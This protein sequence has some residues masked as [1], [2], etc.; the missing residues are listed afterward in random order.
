MTSIYSGLCSVKQTGRG[1]LVGDAKVSTAVVFFFLIVFLVLVGLRLSNITDVKVVPHV[2]QVA[3][4]V[5]APTVQEPVV[6][7][8]ALTT[9]KPLLLI[10][11][12]VTHVLKRSKV[13]STTHHHHHTKKRVHTRHH[14]N[15]LRDDVIAFSKVQVKYLHESFCLT[16]SVAEVCHGS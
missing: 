4:I 16:R 3:K 1:S 2:E 11:V 8:V 14:H 10:G 5:D 15:H 12:P 13:K 6:A 7:E 9:V